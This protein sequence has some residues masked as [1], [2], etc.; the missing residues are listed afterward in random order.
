M[1][2]AHQSLFRN[3]R[4]RKHLEELP[5]KQQQSPR[6]KIWTW[7]QSECG[8]LNT[9]IPV[10]WGCSVLRQPGNNCSSLLTLCHRAVLS[11]GSGSVGN[12]RV[13]V[14]THHL[15]DP[16]CPAALAAPRGL[17][18]SSELLGNGTYFTWASKEEKKMAI[19]IL[20]LVVS[21]AQLELYVLDWG[22]NNILIMCLLEEQIC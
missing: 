19:G 3:S 7:T 18:V 20:I 16:W 11:D 17:T 10:F 21:L 4:K 15:D 8:W 22:Q 13:R 12:T 2:H 5:R 1:V 9:A 6:E 14:S